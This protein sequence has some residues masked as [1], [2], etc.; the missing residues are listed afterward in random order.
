MEGR[1]GSS[2]DVEHGGVCRG[3]RG[4]REALGM[5]NMEVCVEEGGEEGKLTWD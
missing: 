3:G 1:K 2:R 5:W 4:G